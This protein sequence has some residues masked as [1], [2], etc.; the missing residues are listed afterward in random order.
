[1]SEQYDAIVVG[2]GIGGLSSALT[3]VSQGLSVCVVEAHA[4]PGGKIGNRVVDGVEFDTGPS[5]LTM[6]YVFDKI[7]RAAGT[8]IEDELELLT[9]SPMFRY[10]YPDG[11]E[12]EVHHELELTRQQ[13]RDVLGWRAQRQFDAFLKYSKGIW[14]AARPN[15]VEGDAPNFMR[16][17]KLG[18]TKLPELMK[19]DP[20]RTMWQGITRHV[21]DPHLRTLFARYATYNGSSPYVAPATLN[22][23]A[24]VELGEGGWGVRGGMSAIPRAMERVA[25]RLGVEFVYDTR[26]AEIVLES[27]VATGVVT[28]SGERVMASAVVANA[29]VAHVIESLLPGSVDHGLPTGQEPSMSGWTGVLKARRRPTRAAHTVYFPRDYAEEFEDIFGRG[30]APKEPTVY[31]C[32]QSVAHARAGWEEHEPIFVMANAPPT[33]HDGRGDAGM[34]AELEEAVL[35]R[36]KRAGLCDPDDELVWTRR[37]MDL[38]AHFPGSRGSIYGA[39]SN[40]QLAAFRRP[41]NRVENIPGLYLASGSAHPGGGVPMCAMSGRNAAHHVLDAIQPA[42]AA[43]RRSR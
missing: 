9:P 41:D 34:Y 32:A 21:K 28:D 17:V 12:L 39:A 37:P 11:V 31:M 19:I 4:Q 7:F 1:M 3:L 43:R 18:V 35:R 23:I 24:W 25:R 30:R 8:S 10:V 27:G 14:D 22:C 40:S 16:A 20:F 36:I 13:V 29:D 38:A 33:A 15:F 2:A 42:V 26:V 5:L 6:P